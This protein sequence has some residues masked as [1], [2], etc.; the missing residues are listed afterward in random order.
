VEA[1][2]CDASTACHFF[3]ADLQAF[4]HNYKWYLD[5]LGEWKNATP[6]IMGDLASQSCRAQNRAYC[7]ANPMSPYCPKTT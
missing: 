5:E 2:A 7:R 3:Y 1:G 6:S 4:R